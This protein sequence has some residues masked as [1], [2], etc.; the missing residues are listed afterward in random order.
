MGFIATG[1]AR[2]CHL[3]CPVGW[4]GGK[5]AGEQARDICLGRQDGAHLLPPVCQLVSMFGYIERNDVLHS[6]LYTVLLLPALAHGP[7]QGL[8]Q[9]VEAT[10]LD[11]GGQATLSRSQHTESE[12]Q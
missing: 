11:S 12:G 2:G 1:S 3:T 9:S 6:N 7:N 5:Q 4:R 8:R 10:Q